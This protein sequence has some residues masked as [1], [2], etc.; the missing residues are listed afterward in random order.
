MPLEIVCSGPASVHPWSAIST[1][2]CNFWTGNLLGGRGKSEGRGGEGRG[3]EG[4]GKSE[5]V[6]RGG[7]GR[8]RGGGGQRE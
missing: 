6:G 7:E 5:G 3:G 8:G 2:T 1:S 4:R